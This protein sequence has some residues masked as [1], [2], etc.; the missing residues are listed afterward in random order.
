MKSEIGTAANFLARL[1]VAG[2]CDADRVRAFTTELTSTLEH[3]YSL[4]WDT[5]K[6]HVGSAFRCLRSEKER[7][8]PVLK[9]LLQ[10]HDLTAPSNFANL[11]LWIDPSDVSY[12]YGE[13]GNISSLTL[14]DDASSSTTS[15]ASSSHPSPAPT[16]RSPAKFPFVACST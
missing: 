2:G 7:V 9:T 15:A 13:Y 10:Q 5:T 16:L 8:D 4:H 3:R 12:R 1:L 11:T 14:T 6:P